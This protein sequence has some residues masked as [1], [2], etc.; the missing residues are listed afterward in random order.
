MDDLYNQRLV[1]LNTDI[2]LRLLKTRR[3][4][5]DELGYESYTD[6]AYKD[7]GYDYTKEDMKQLLDDIGNYISPIQHELN[8]VTFSTYFKKNNQPKLDKVTMINTLYKAYSKGNA[9]FK[10]AYSYM[11]QHGL[12]NISPSYPN[13]Y[14]GAFTAYIDSNNSPYIFAT[15]SGFL[16]D[17]NSISH[18]FGHFYDGF[19]N[20]GADISLDLAE[21]SSQAMQLLT[22]LMLR[23]ELKLNEYEYLEYLTMYN[24]LEDTLLKQSFYAEF[25]HLVY[26]LEFDE[27]T[28][29]NV[30]EAV[31]NAYTAI[32]GGELTA[33]SPVQYV[34]ILHVILRPH[35][36]ESY[37]ASSIPALEI[38]SM[39]SYR[40]GTR[41]S[42]IEAYKN[43]I[44]RSDTTLSFTAALAEAGLSSP[45]E[46]TTV[47]KIANCIYFQI[48]G[49]NYYQEAK[50]KSNAA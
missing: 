47:E 28:L 43:L 11:L 12:Y 23:N 13:R 27:I 35:Y 42:G 46:T 44:E 3:L 50:I 15:T 31:L 1:T 37:V 36:V 48:L 30:N 18:E 8:S 32:Y 7:I 14:S 19:V 4:I 33:M 49:K 34:L 26:Q 22:L 10:D 40:T 21:V 41:G 2:Y 6:F 16:K 39:E 24:M 29:K 20:N 5:A 45:F 38:F 9:D 25:E 17:Y